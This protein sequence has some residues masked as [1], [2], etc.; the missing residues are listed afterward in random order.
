MMLHELQSAGDR[1]SS[2]RSSKGVKGGELAPAHL[3]PDPKGS[4][5]SPNT[6]AICSMDIFSI[7]SWQAGAANL[8]IDFCLGTPRAVQ[9][10]IKSEEFGFQGI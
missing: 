2:L 10:L 7:I 4:E 8:S 9:S 5:R 1:W 6:S 3:V